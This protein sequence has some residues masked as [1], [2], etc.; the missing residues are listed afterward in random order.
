MQSRLLAVAICCLMVA[1]PSAAAA[2][3]T[4][5]VGV[6][7]GYNYSTLSYERVFS[8]WDIEG[9]SMFSVGAFLD[10]PV[11]ERLSF[12]PEMRY[13]RY[14]DDVDFDTGDEF[15]TLKGEYEIT[16]SYL[17][18][19]ALVKFRPMD[20]VP[21]FVSLGPEIGF[22]LSAHQKGNLREEYVSPD[23]VAVSDFDNDIGDIMDVLNLS[24][25]AGAGFEF[26]LGQHTGSVQVRYAFGVLGTAK[27]KEWYSDWKTRG[28]EVIG[29]LTW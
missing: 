22:L 10:V 18:F 25:D 1:L 14:G 21:L 26:P 20:T 7:G 19:P 4:V 9:R 6:E 12:V 16:Q 27:E 23:S 28:V 15:V 13:I 29:G 11:T 3:G 24:L 2:A 17:S 5:R 8:F